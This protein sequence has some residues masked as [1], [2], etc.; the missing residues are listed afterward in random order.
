MHFMDRKALAGLH[1]I[2]SNNVKLGI[3]ED[4]YT[5]IRSGQPQ[6]AAVSRSGP[7]PTGR[8]AP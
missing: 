6:W 5:D 3:V 4:V 8:P 2:G 1:V 7:L